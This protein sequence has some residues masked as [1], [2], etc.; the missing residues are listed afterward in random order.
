LISVIIRFKNE[1]NYLKAVL[2]AVR[3]QRTLEPV[4]VVVVD[5][6]ST[7]GSR[8]IAG[9]YADV[10]LDIQDYHPGAALNQAIS[11]CS[12]DAIAVLSAHAL[13]ANSAWLD[14]ISSWLTNPAVLATYGSQ[15]YPIDSRFLDKRDLDIFSDLRPR[16]EARDSDLWNANSVFQ[17]TA[18]EKLPFN[19]DVYE[20]EDHYWSKR[21]LSQGDQWVRFEPSALV[22]HYGHA[23]RN[24]RTFLPLSSMTDE[25]RVQAAIAVLERNDEPWPAV[26]SAGLTLSSLA[27]LPVA[28]EAVPVLGRVLNIHP[29]FDVRWRVAGALGRIRHEDSVSC[30]VRSLTDRS[31]YVR[32]EVAWSLGRLGRQ[33]VPQVLQAASKIELKHQPFA[34]LALGLSKDREGGLA[35]VDIL[36]RCLSEGDQGVRRD[37]LYFLGEIVQVV[38]DVISLVPVVARHL[39]AEDDIVARAAAWCW[40]EISAVQGETVAPYTG[41]VLGLARYHPVETVRFEAVASIGKAVPGQPKANLV[42][43]VHQALREDGVGRVRYGAVQSLRRLAARG[44]GV[45][46]TSDHAGD[47]D[48]GVRFESGLLAQQLDER[49]WSA[50]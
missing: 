43:Y 22:Y 18:W 16:T 29:D 24:D 47:P 25:Q 26:M 17:R 8:T 9:E 44:I 1:A 28:V 3:A 15:L 46:G 35:A 5:N 30:L 40:G 13:P 38:P 50:P 45:D 32:D 48:F 42:K 10:L 19:E 11:A 23:T 31:F 21:H 49:R 4:E 7:D 6:R 39:E 37:A 36:R 27:H 20:L 33:A 2:Q 14:N 12:G 41:I 34:A